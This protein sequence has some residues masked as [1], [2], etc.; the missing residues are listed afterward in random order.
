[1]RKVDTEMPRDSAQARET[2]SNST[3]MPSTLEMVWIMYRRI[4]RVLSAVSDVHKESISCASCSNGVT[5]PAGANFSSLTKTPS[6]V[7]RLERSSLEM[8]GTTPTSSDPAM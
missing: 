5:I 8:S 3:S 6:L 2:R 1:M 7:P 4:G